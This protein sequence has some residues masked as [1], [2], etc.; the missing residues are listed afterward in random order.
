M[1][2]YSIWVENADGQSKEI[3]VQLSDVEK[4][5]VLD[6]LHGLSADGIL[7]DYTVDPYPTDSG[8]D[9]VESELAPLLLIERD[10]KD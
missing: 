7:A 1:T 10:I 9:F 4:Q 3:D 2:G 6:I 5:E 8:V